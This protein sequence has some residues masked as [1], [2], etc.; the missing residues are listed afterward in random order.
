MTIHE[1]T[2]NLQALRELCETGEY[3][4]QTLADTM[5]AVEGEFR[6]RRR[7]TLG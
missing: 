2:G 6:K 7:A 4:E 5:E 3:D 1:I